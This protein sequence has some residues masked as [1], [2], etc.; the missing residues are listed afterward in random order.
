MTGSPILARGESPVPGILLLLGGALMAI[1]GVVT[2]NSPLIVGSIPFILIGAIL[3]ATRKRDLEFVIE[4]TGL[5]ILRPEPELIQYADMEMVSFSHSVNPETDF[6]FAI[7]IAHRDG[8][9]TIP[10]GINEVGSRNLYLFLHRMVPDRKANLPP[11]S[12]NEHYERQLD[13]FELD[14]VWALRT[15]RYL[16][17][18]RFRRGWLI[19]LALILSGF[20]FV[21]AAGDRVNRNPNDPLPG[22]GGLLLLAGII[23]VLIYT[24]QSSNHRRMLRESRRSGLVLSP[25]GLAMVQGDL[26]GKMRWEEIR[27]ITWANN[28]QSIQLKIDGGM[29]MIHDAFNEALPI[30]YDL[31]WAYWD[32]PE[33]N[34]RI[35]N[36]E[37]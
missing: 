31:L 24:V 37:Y 2:Q 29:F 28:G 23:M 8:I 1:P 13:Q 26:K 17:D 25:I 35:T 3:I 36:E 18:R 22:F 6:S 33:Q 4:S 27:T 7:T 16:S 9:L 12:L 15:R 5:E 14:R 20:I 21:G 30:I 10:S 11:D 32:H 19:S 34:R